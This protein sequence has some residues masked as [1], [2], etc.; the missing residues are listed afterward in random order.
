MTTRPY[1]VLAI[2]VNGR[3]TV[4]DRKDDRIAALVLRDTLV[5]SLERRRVQETYVVVHPDVEGYVEWDEDEEWEA[6]AN[7]DALD[8]RDAVLNAQERIDRREHER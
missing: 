2:D 1:E 7:Q 6:L 8:E 5:R 3:E 4:L